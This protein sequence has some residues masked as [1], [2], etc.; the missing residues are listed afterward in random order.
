MEARKLRIHLFSA[1]L[2]IRDLVIKL[3]FSVPPDLEIRDLGVDLSG[4]LPFQKEKVFQD[5]RISQGHFPV[6]PGLFA[7]VLIALVLIYAGLIPTALVFAGRK[8]GGKRFCH[9]AALI[10]LIFRVAQGGSRLQLCLFDLSGQVFQVLF[11]SL[12]LCLHLF[13]FADCLTG[14]PALL[15]R[16]LLIQKVLPDQVLQGYVRGGGLQAIPTGLS[17]QSLTGGLL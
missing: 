17:C 7:G 15:L 11:Q 12:Q 5:G 13:S 2:A 10:G 1:L 6:F 9:P 8:S 14:G 16:L 4:F 3:L